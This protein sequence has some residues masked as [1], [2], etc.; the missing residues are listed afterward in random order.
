MRSEILHHSIGRLILAGLFS[1]GAAMGARAVEVTEQ[2]K[3]ACTPDAFRL[4][5]A[6]IPDIPRV[7]ACMEANRAQLSAPCRAVFE[8]MSQPAPATASLDKPQP[9]L[10]HAHKKLRHYANYHE[11]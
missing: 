1:L 8:A 9:K 2:Q 7:T 10:V 6:E 5:S 11:G 4:C 3:Q